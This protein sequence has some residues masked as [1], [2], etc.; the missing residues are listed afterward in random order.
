M[1]GYA[2]QTHTISVP[3]S[4]GIDGFLKTLRGILALPRVQSIS[5]DSKGAVKYSRYV[6]EGENDAPVNVDYAGL[7]PWNIIRN[8]ELEPIG[9]HPL[10]PAPAV[11]AV[12]FDHVIRAGLTPIAF[13]TGAAS[14]FWSWHEHSAGLSL[15]R[16]NS[17]Y[18]LPIYMDRQMPDHALVLCAAYVKGGLTDCHRFFMADMNAQ[19][20]EAPTT[21]VNIL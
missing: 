14:E 16:Q 3:K 8:G 12:M 4:T 1:E 18:G 19:E 5:I 20:F 21:S 10:T 11:I 2:E 6:R 9:V 15:V 13:A 7:E 17:A